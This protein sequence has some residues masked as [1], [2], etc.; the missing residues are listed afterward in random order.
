MPEFP[1]PEFQV[2]L[3][4]L[5]GPLSATPPPTLFSSFDSP[6][7]GQ[8]GQVPAAFPCICHTL[9]GEGCFLLQILKSYHPLR[10]DPMSSSGRSRCSFLQLFVCTFIWHI[11]SSSTVITAPPG[12][13]HELV[14]CFR[15]ASLALPQH[16]V[17]GRRSGPWMDTLLL[18]TGLS[19]HHGD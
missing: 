11:E 7:R 8:T 16:P 17:P 18:G 14:L 13:T 4:G 15:S 3:S 12:D 2:P 1:V 9:Q 19:D 6:W 5:K 10:G